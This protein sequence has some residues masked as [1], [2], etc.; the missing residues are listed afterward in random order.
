MQH[1]FDIEIAATYGI[2]SAI[3]LNNIA[4]WTEKNMANERHFYDGRYWTYNSQKAFSVLFPY[5]TR[6]NIRTIIVKS[7]EDG[8]IITGNYNEN[9]MNSTSWYALTDLGLTLFP[10]LEFIKKSREIRDG[11]N[12]PLGGLELTNV[13]VGTNQPSITDI[14]SYKREEP[15]LKKLSTTESKID[16]PSWLKKDAWDE[17][18]EHRRNIKKPMSLLAEKKLLS[19]LEILKNEGQDPYEI[20][21]ESIINGWSGLFGLY[22]KNNFVKKLN[23]NQ[24]NDTCSTVKFWRAG[25]PDYDRL[26]KQ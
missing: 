11:C 24:S 16:F 6:Q 22:K 15:T 2:N 21:N 4:F 3:F 20:I 8:L 5:W 26:H 10:R 13:V 25:N 7:K 12:Q 14:N 17:F 18:R 9:K 23:N 19:K 1:S